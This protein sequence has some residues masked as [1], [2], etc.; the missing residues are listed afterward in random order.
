MRGVPSQH[1]EK[2]ERRSEWVGGCG[3][4]GGGGGGARKG[5]RGGGSNVQDKKTA[6]HTTKLSQNSLGESHT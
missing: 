4:M 2:G 3:G 5:V 1:V 6:L